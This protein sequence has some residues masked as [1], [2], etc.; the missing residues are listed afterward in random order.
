VNFALESWVKN[1]YLYN[2]KA[3]V[4]RS[5]TVKI[6][7]ELFSEKLIN[8]LALSDQN[9][10]NKLKLDKENFSSPSKRQKNLSP[11]QKSPNKINKFVEKEI[12][13]KKKKKKFKSFIKNESPRC[14]R[15]TI[16]LI[17]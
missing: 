9:S 3:C 4:C 15:A 2:A 14:L 13:G 16:K 10:I 11:K 12:K 6:N 17:K 5:D 7:K 1:K 8:N